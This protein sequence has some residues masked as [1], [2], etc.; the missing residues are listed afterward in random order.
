MT[1]QS[2]CLKMKVIITLLV[3]ALAR[4]ALAVS[5]EVDLG[6][7]KYVGLPLSNSITQW[8]GIRFAAP[9]L[10]DLRFRAPQ[11]PLFDP[12]VQQASQVR[13]ST[14]DDITMY[15]PALITAIISSEDPI[16]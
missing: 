6:Y 14:H 10:G 9:P 15:D 8:L 4:G 2:D 13:L 3:A 1:L 5:P 16:V 11:A 12:A 7:S